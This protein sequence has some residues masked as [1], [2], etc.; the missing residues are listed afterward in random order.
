MSF[1]PEPSVVALVDV[2]RRREAPAQMEADLAAFLRAR[3]VSGEDLDVLVSTGA[4]RLLVYRALVHNRLRNATRDFIPRAIARLG[5][6][7]FQADFELFVDEHAA[8]SY[9]LRDVP[10]EFVAWVSP[11]W[12]ADDSVPNYLA[13]LARHELL[14]LTVRNAPGGGE[15]PTD[16]PVA[17]DR[18]LRFDGSARLMAYDHAVHRLPSKT[19]DRTVPTAEPTRLLV[20]R[21]PDHK[22][23]YLELS[24]FAAAALVHLIDGR[25]PVAAALQAGAS[26]LGRALDD[27]A[28]AAAA[29]LLADLAERKVMLGAD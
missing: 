20:Y 12:A 27:D 6:R 1:E 26:D 5:R 25:Q 15:A 4:E 13:D 11:R 3:G 9:Y 21:D 7:R 22:V 16:A 23:R 18:P 10:E 29:L 19:S 2:I 24:A 17:L 28:L 14:Q 8:V